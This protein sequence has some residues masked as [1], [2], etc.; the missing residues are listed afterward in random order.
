MFY[1]LILILSIIVF[2]SLRDFGTSIP[3]QLIL[4]MCGVLIYECIILGYSNRKISFLLC[5]LTLAIILRVNSVIILP[6]FLLLIFFYYFRIPKYIKE[7]YLL[8]VCLSII[9]SFL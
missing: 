4:I 1:Y 2:S 9:I 6:I 7:N 8:V 5:L 3:P